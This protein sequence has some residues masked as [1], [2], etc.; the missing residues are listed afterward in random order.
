[1]P[2]LNAAQ[3]SALTRAA[4]A[5]DLIVDVARSLLLQ[6]LPA[7][8]RGGLSTDT[9]PLDQFSL[10]LGRMNEVERLAEGLVPIVVYLQNAADQLALRSRPESELFKQIANEIGNRARG[11]AVID[12]PPPATLPE[13][14]QHEAIVGRDDMVDFDFLNRALT[15]GHSIG[16]ILVPRFF[17]GA[18]V[19]LASG[20]P[21]VL[22]GTAWL[23][24]PRLVVTNHHVV[25]VRAAEEA[26]ASA[27]DLRLQ[28]TNATVE[29]DFDRAAADRVLSIGVETLAFESKSLDYAILRLSRDPE[30]P[31][32]V[33][34]PARIQ[35]TATSYLPV[36]II[37]HP[38]GEPKRVAFRN[39]LV[40][41]ADK[42]LI[43]YFTD[44][45]FG[46]SGSPVCGDDWRVVA[47]HRGAKYTSGVTYQGKDTA[48]VNFG[49]QIQAIRDDVRAGNP[50][51]HS[52]IFGA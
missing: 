6:G 18:Q 2:W 48:Y 19:R 38:R 49:S 34:N 17:N 10:D 13:V 25:N 1:M 44:T 47:L 31:P 15:A 21:W 7:G 9:K 37:Q 33:I 41:G 11:K 42:D 36:N 39:N 40:T 52:E 28:S 3:I 51:L 30:R 23:I 27:A 16:R 8:F 24:A 5:S 29:F 14:T 22:R 12:L 45:D 43:R 20:E 46:S 35:M 50:Q 4:I 26:D 32:L